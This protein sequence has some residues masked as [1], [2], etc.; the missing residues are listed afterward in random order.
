MKSDEIYVYKYS[1]Y[2]NTRQRSIYYLRL[3]FIQKLD[4]EDRAGNKG[5]KKTTF[6]FFWLGL[7]VI[8]E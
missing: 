7:T 2:N 5:F 4:T 1:G 8:R 6:F 3:N